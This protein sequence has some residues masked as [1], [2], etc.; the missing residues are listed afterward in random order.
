VRVR[1][2][3]LDIIELLLL[4]SSCL[5]Q[6]LWVQAVAGLQP[7]GTTLLQLQ[8]KQKALHRR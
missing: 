2:H 1:L 6:L 8:L 7:S 3:L 5:L 4:Q